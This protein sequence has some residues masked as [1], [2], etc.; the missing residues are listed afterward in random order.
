MRNPLP[1]EPLVRW[2]PCACDGG[3][4]GRL[5]WVAAATNSDLP[6]PR[7]THLAKLSEVQ[8]EPRG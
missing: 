8:R 4:P 5:S 7:L 6:I 2:V 3:G 1:D